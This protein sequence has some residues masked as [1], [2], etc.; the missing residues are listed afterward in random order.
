[1]PEIELRSEEVQEIIGRTPNRL[2]QYGI[3]VIFSIVILLLAGSFFFKYPDIIQ[4]RIVLTGN[5]PPAEIKA[6]T[7]GKI[8][9]FFIKDKQEVKKDEILGIIEN[10]TVYNDFKTLKQQIPGLKIFINSSQSDILNFHV[11]QNLRLGDLQIQYSKLL[12][13][14]SNYKDFIV[15]DYHNKKKESLRNQI[16]ANQKYLQNLKRQEKLSRNDL[17]L[18]QKQYN[19]DSILFISKS[20]SAFEL[21][22]SE[23]QL[24]QK[25]YAYESAKNAITSTEITI[26]GLEQNNIEL[27]KQYYEQKAN[28]DISLRETYE[29]LLAQIELWEQTYMLKSPVNGQISFDK[30]WTDNQNVTSGETVFIVVPPKTSELFGRAE[31]PAVG[32]GKVKKGQRVN[33]KFD[34]FPHTQFGSVRAKVEDISLVRTNE[35]YLVT[36]SFPDSLNTNYRKQIPFVQNMQGSAEIITEDLPLIARLINPLKKLFYENL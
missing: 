32:A 3:T 2:I 21:E 13:D 1:M 12:S 8:T 26:S 27:E 36:V 31:I 24:L 10:T 15:L 17:I 16:S 23:S 19:R 25:K 7:N 11:L 30:Y 5:N 14:I 34:D 28:F 35:K 22:K 18:T 29:N 4:A 33:I 9:Q 20:I 6:R